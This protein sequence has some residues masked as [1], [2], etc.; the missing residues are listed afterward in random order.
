MEVTFPLGDRPDCGN[1]FSSDRSFEDI[2]RGICFKK[3]AY[4]LPVVILAQ[5][6]YLNTGVAFFYLQG[7][8]E[9]SES[10]HCDIH[11]YDIGLEPRGGF[12][13]LFAVRCLSNDFN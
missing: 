6:K 11:E 10:R 4:I 3:P 1:K 9:S 12:N 5:D 8:L 2:A 7:G 13:R